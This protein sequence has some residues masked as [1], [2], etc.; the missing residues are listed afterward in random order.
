MSGIEYSEVAPSRGW[1]KAKSGDREVSFAWP[2]FQGTHQDCCQ[3]IAKDKELVPAEGLDLAIL[4]NGAYSQNTPQWT[5]VKG[6]FRSNWVR[7]PNRSLLI[8]A[9]HF[10]G[11]KQLAGILVER[12]L[13]GNGLSTKMQVP[14]LYD[15]KQNDSGIY[16]SPD[17]NASFAPSS[18]Y[19]GK[20]FE[21][22]GVAHIHLTSEGAE[23]FAKTAKDAGLKPYNWLAQRMKEITSTEQ[24][25]SLLGECVGRLGLDGFDWGGDR[26]GPAFGVS[27]SREASAPKI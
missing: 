15:W 27:A 26:Y 20:S 17:R 12:D 11:D 2:S 10:K 23:L 9:G 25:V 4:T 22:D 21:K 3:A 19:E 13:K 7:A 8:P 24:R 6:N 5:S 14:D 1:L 18:S 16:I